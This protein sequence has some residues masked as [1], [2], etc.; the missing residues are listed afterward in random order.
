MGPGRRADWG[1]H[2]T[3]YSL[4]KLI[5]A[6][7]LAGLLA[8]CGHQV[9]TTSG[10]KY[11]TAY[12]ESDASIDREVATDAEIAAAAN[13]EPHLHFPARIGLARIDEQG[14]IAV[15]AAE[16]E[17]WRD[18][19]GRLG[20]GYGTFVP[21]SPLVAALATPHP[22][23]LVVTLNQDRARSYRTS[24]AR[25]VREI[26]LGAARQH[27]DAVLIYET[28]GRSEESSNPL[29]LTKL[30][31]IGFFL[32]TESVKAE[33]A[34]QAVLVDVRNGYTYGT[35]SAVAEKPAAR[36][37]TVADSGDAHISARAEAE[38]RAVAGLAVEV[39]GM[40]RELRLALAE[41]RAAGS[42]P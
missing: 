9:Q 26:R 10:S 18:L 28:F 30:A 4:P 20:S 5:L 1:D 41:G 40:V 2:M 34:A 22:S 38:A 12:T 11:L 39:E 36:L 35:A 25:V 19:A 32:P 13:V 17:A 24:L 14:L 21:V 8:A 3:K 29:A 37:T 15:P 33:G 42:L 27:L 6:G 23:K 31:L 7:G 16:A